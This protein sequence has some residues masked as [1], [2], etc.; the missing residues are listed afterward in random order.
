MSTIALLGAGG[1]LGHALQASLA[2]P[3]L[4]IAK[5]SDVDITDSQSVADFLPTEGFVI[6]AAAYTQVDQAESDPESA[7]AVNGDAVRII[8]EVAKKKTSRLIHVSTD[9]V[10]DGVASQ[11][12]AEDAP[13]HPASVYGKSKRAGEEHVLELL[14]HSG[15]IVRTAWLYGEHGTS[16]PRTILRLGASQDTLDVVDDQVGQPTWAHDVAEMIAALVSQG[17]PAGIVH[18]TNSGQ[19]TW[20]GFAQRLFEL[21]GWDPGRITPVP[22]Q[23]F[24]RPAPRPAWSVL[25]HSNWVRL[26]MNTPRHWHDALDEAW[27][28]ELSP[29]AQ[30]INSA[31]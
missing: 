29:F 16:F 30:E 17:A 3:D 23:K 8:A 15:S 24:I 18:A 10:F 26:G 5:R 20:F 2:G 6:N 22:S 12:Y 14:P 9:Y 28:Q 21:A 4:V 31:R 27:D 13:C 1:M 25:G 11:P 7:Y 19:T